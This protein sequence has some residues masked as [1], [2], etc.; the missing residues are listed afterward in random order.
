MKIEIGKEYMLKKSTMGVRYKAIV[1]Y[2]TKTNVL[3]KVMC[4]GLEDE[5]LYPI[6]MF[7]DT[8]KLTNQSK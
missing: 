3:C 6:E 2:I 4:S 5:H 7:K 8:Y 1:L